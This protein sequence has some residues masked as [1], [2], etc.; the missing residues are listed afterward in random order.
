MDPMVLFRG[1][2]RVQGE[3]VRIIM[4]P[5]KNLSYDKNQPAPKPENAP[6]PAASDSAK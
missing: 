1:E 6:V 5:L 3:N 4:P 2:R